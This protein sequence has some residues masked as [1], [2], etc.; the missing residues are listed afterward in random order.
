MLKCVCVCV[1]VCNTILGKRTSLVKHGRIDIVQC[2]RDLPRTKNH[3]PSFSVD[4]MRATVGNY[5]IYPP[6]VFTLVIIDF[7]FHSVYS[8]TV[9]PLSYM[10]FSV[11]VHTP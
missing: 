4:V 1:C 3:L 10:V 9:L 11:K 7:L 8:Q 5:S 6:S 2:L